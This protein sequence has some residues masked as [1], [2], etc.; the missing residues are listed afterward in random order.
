MRG[1]TFDPPDNRRLSDLDNFTQHM[2]VVMTV[3]GND[4]A[5]ITQAGIGGFLSK[6]LD[7]AAAY[8][9]HLQTPWPG[10]GAEVVPNGVFVA[11]SNNFEF[12]A[13]ADALPVAAAG[14]ARNG[15]ILMRW[16][17]SIWTIEQY[18]EI[19]VSRALIRS[20][21]WRAFVVRASS[22]DP[23]LPVIMGLKAR[24]GSTDLSS[25]TRRGMR[26]SQTSSFT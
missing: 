8:V 25:S 6:N 17:I 26:S 19:G 18:S 15:M 5:K 1:P 2:L 20:L 24:T 23:Q 11:D 21:P 13:G 10:F 9:G 7:E 4:I 16:P 12:T 3:G 14:L 22:D